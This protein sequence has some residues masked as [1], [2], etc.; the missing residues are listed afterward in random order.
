MRH[1]RK[2]HLQDENLGAGSSCIDT[3]MEVS[4]DEELPGG[5]TAQQVLDFAEGELTSELFWYDDGIVDESHRGYATGVTVSVAGTGT[6]RWIDSE[7][8]PDADNGGIEP[9]F[10]EL[11][12]DR[13][14]VDVAVIFATDDG[15]FAESEST[16]LSS[17]DGSAASFRFDVDAGALVGDLDGAATFP[18]WVLRSVSFTGHYSEQAAAWG[19]VWAEVESEDQG[20]DGVV[21]FGI[22]ASWG[23]NPEDGQ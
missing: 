8:D 3:P 23:D 5:F 4:L 15:E 22:V 14:V 16:A 7:P 21:G 11:C 1:G 2:R 20:P 10:E 18:D 12:E 19:E 9:A 6:A 17:S 13:L